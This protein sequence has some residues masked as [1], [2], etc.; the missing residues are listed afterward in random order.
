MDTNESRACEDLVQWRGELSDLVREANR[1]DADE[2]ATALL[3]RAT[4]E[5]VLEKVIADAVKCEEL[6]AWAQAVHFLDGLDIEEGYED[7]LTQ[8]LF[9]TSTP[10]VREPDTA[11]HCHRWLTRIRTSLVASEAAGR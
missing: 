10:E 9:E 3:D 5:I 6:T 11:G 7:L 2:S 1:A 8:F 4:A